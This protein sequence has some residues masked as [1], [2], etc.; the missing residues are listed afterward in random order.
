MEIEAY[1]KEGNHED[2]ELT[3]FRGK[4]ESFVRHPE[5]GAIP[6]LNGSGYRTV[7]VLWNDSGDMDALSPWEIDLRGH[8]PEPCRVSLTDNEK[9]RVRESLKKIRD[10]D[11]VSS[12]FSYPVNEVAYSDYRSRIEVPMDLTFIANRLHTDYYSSLMSVVAD[13]KLIKDNCLKYNGDNDE[14]SRIAQRMLVKCEELLLEE[15]DLAIYRAWQAE[16]ESSA[17][18]RSEVNPE[19]L[20]INEQRQVDTTNLDRLVGQTARID[21]NSRSSLENLAPPSS[22]RP[23]MNVGADESTAV[24]P[25]TIRSLR[26][27]RR[28]V[29]ETMAVNNRTLEDLSS[30]GR[31]TR[32]RRVQNRGGAHRSLRSSQQPLETLMAP[33]AESDTRNMDLASR[34]SAVEGNVGQNGT[35]Q[36]QRESRSRL[37]L[38]IQAPPERSS[39]RRTRS[40]LR[41]SSSHNQPLAPSRP[42]RGA[43]TRSGSSG[44]S[45]ERVRPGFYHEESSDDDE[46]FN[47]RGNSR[48][49]QRRAQG[50]SRRQENDSDHDTSDGPEQ[51][52][53]DEATE[54]YMEEEEDDDDISSTVESSSDES[55]RSSTKIAKKTVR[56]EETGKGSQRSQRS[57]T[58]RREPVSPV[59][60]RK[61][62]RAKEVVNRESVMASTFS[63][64]RTTRASSGTSNKRGR[65]SYEDP[66]SSE[67]GTDIEDESAP[68]NK[69]KAAKT[70]PKKRPKRETANS[71]A[72]S[73][74]IWPDIPVKMIT[75]VSKDIL[76]RLVSNLLT[77]LYV[78]HLS[79]QM[80]TLTATYVYLKNKI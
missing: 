50:Y 62:P 11:G 38:R 49:N 67:F 79:E 40:T 42:Q 8:D 34:H 15:E 19:P 1:Y 30:S 9:R 59:P 71:E 61:S 53:N 52:S 37:R 24:L 12:Y 26:R 14:T 58:T 43:T 5:T 74:P 57:Q 31:G 80:L 21:S 7:T 70:A 46:S 51:E 28:S 10:I 4:A 32:G 68:V 77:L 48:K 27:S 41:E 22:E 20:V 23:S 55:S 16:V 75:L 18:C 29:L 60:A 35:D 56:K 78:I 2:A 73:P 25:A 54:V 76:E 66:S 64:R 17:Q 3:A 72:S 45:G 39:S 33:G 44:I 6:H 65:A 13:V 36:V 69:A 47:E 63:N